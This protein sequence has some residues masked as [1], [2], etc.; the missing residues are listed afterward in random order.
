[1]AASCCTSICA[2]LRLKSVV[3]EVSFIS[4]VSLPQ[5]LQALELS[6]LRC[7]S[8]RHTYSS[9]RAPLRNAA[10]NQPLLSSSQ[11]TIT[12][13][14]P[15]ALCHSS[16]ISYCTHRRGLKSLQLCVDVCFLVCQ[17]LLLGN[18]MLYRTLLSQRPFSDKNLDSR[19]S[20]TVYLLLASP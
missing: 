15:A 20:R 16:L 6:E 2:V 18:I 8:I 4:V 11:C 1:M 10:S 13:K 19:T 14:P 5:C 12:H 3:E 7:Q 17:P 9:H